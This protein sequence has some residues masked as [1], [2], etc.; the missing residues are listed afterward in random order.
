MKKLRALAILVLCAQSI[1]GQLMLKPADTTDALLPQWAKM[2]Y[3]SHVNV[4]KVEKELLKYESEYG[5]QSNYHTAYYKHW[6]R[7]MRPYI[8]DDGYIKMPESVNK[9]AF[10][11]SDSKLTSLIPNKQLLPWSFAGPEKHYR[12]RYNANDTVTQVS[13]HANM[14]C[15]DQSNS[16]TN[17]LY[18]GSENG[19][20]Y[21]STDKGL[22]WQFISLNQNMTTVSALAIN[23]TNENEVLVNADYQTYLTTDGGNSWSTPL[24]PLQNILVWQFLYNPIN[25]QIIFA[26]AQNGLYRT[27]DGGT[28]WLQIFSRE[29]M[30]VE[31]QAGNP[32]VVF[33]LQYNDTTKIAG[34]YKSLD[35]GV[36]FTLKPNGWFQVP[37][38]DAGLLQSYGGRIAAT[39]AD[40]NRLYVLLVGQS[41]TAAQLQLHGQIGVYRSNDGGENWTHPHGLIG[42]PYSVPNHPN[43]MTFNGNNDTYNQIYYNTALVVSQLDADKIL[44]GG[45]SMWKSTDGAASFEPVG[46]YIGNVPLIHPDNQEFKIYKTSATTEELWFANDGGINYSTDFLATHESRCNGLFGSAYWGF[47]QGW[48]D[49]IMVGGRYHNGNA[50]RRDGYA[51]GAYL[52]LGG[53]EAPTGYVNYSNEKKTYYSDI[54]GVVLPDTLN[55]VAGTFPV[56]SEP[57]ESYADN[58][59]SRIMFDWDYWNVAY[60]GKNNKILV[61]TNGGSSYTDLYSFGSNTNH[62]VYWIEQSRINTQVIYAQQVINGISKIWKTNDKGISWTQIPL[63]QNKRDL[64]FTLSYNNAD[65]LWISYAKGSNGNK[66]YHTTNSGINWTNITTTDLD[67]LECNAIAHQFGTNGGIYIGT[68]H[69]PVFYR[70]NAQ[71]NWQMVGT[72]IPAISYPLRLVPFYRDNK[73][74]LATWHLGIWENALHE[75]SSLVADFSANYEAFFCPGDTISFVP[76]CVAS[77]NATYQWTFTGANPP[78]STLKYPNVV[79]NT[80]GVYDVS[81]SVTDNGVTDTKLKTNFIKAVA[82]GVLPIQ[83][84]FET[85]SF[86]A[87]W[88]LY[89]TGTTASNW[90]INT[91]LGGFSNSTHCMFYDNYNYDAQGAHDAVWTAKYDIT[92]LQQG[93]LFFDVAYAPYG[94][95]YQD[96]LEVLVSTD[97]G[98]SFT[99]YYLKGG[100]TLATAPA[101][102]A[103][104]FVPTATQWRTDTIDIT[105]LAGNNEVLFA[106]KNIGRYGQPIYI[107]NINTTGAFTSLLDIKDA[108]SISIFP[109]PVSHTLLLNTDIIDADFEWEIYNVNGKLMFT[110]K[111]PLSNSVLNVTGSR[112]VKI[113]TSALKSGAYYLRIT[114]TGKNGVAKF[115]KTAY[116]LAE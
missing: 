7:Y 78:T 111:A 21:K 15:I 73:I 40:T 108:L 67:G 42:A 58:S 71:S 49:D 75:P 102:S 112:E 82:N 109:N 85:G 43:M 60:M 6:R 37:A 104:I 52:Q 10:E 33:A 95:Q 63:P 54:D 5:K 45:L 83:E 19:G 29:C 98:N 46:G 80:T 25:P 110:G 61:S 114:A 27:A 103:S 35:G 53:G 64:V 39:Q 8:Q 24:L 84:G 77:A 92:N 56:N 70:N 74:R 94:G 30:S 44:I 72:G 101:Y 11:K 22:S 16:N 50:A 12:A 93:K 13:W 90:S 91:S 76:H 97:C 28:T 3:G 96:T 55:G 31:F 107:D 113:N 100:A 68:Y 2:M 32:N 79:Y 57:N 18:A 116:L 47:D 62:N 89:G 66:V 48:N 115:I 69:G 26:A 23:P 17:T 105:N 86:G 51:A 38:A 20:V 4:Y 1:Y 81:L 41:Q 88:K 59:S 14:Y 87:E 9:Q 34:F 65:E 36:T 99:S 106:F